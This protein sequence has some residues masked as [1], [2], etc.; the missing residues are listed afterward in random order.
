MVD[1]ANLNIDIHKK[2]YDPFCG[3][4]GFLIKTF[5]YLKKTIKGLK[6]MS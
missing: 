4:G 6:K 3:T 2:I 1:F 5:S